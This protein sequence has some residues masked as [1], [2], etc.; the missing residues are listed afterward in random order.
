MGFLRSLRNI[1]NWFTDKAGLSGPKGP[2]KR[3]HEEC[4]TISNKR[5]R[6]DDSLVEIVEIS[7]EFLSETEEVEI[8]EPG[9]ST[10]PLRASPPVMLIE[11][12]QHPRRTMSPVRTIDLTESNDE[13]VKVKIIRSY[14]LSNP[15]LISNRSTE[16]VR[17]A[18]TKAIREERSSIKGS[19]PLSLS[20]EGGFSALKINDTSTNASMDKS[21]AM[22]LKHYVTPKP[23]TNILSVSSSRSPMSNHKENILNQSKSSQT[24]GKENLD[25]PELSIYSNR[26]IKKEL[27]YERILRKFKEKQADAILTS[28]TRIQLKSPDDI[29]QEKLEI[30]KKELDTNEPQKKNEVFP[31]YSEEVVES[32]KLQLSGSLNEYIVQGKTI[33]KMDLKTVY[34][35]SAWLNDEVINHYLSMIVARDPTNIH[36]FDTFF[37][38]KLSSQ[39][40]Q[41][42]RRWSRKKDIFACKKMFSPIHLGNHWCL[43]C[44]NF[45]EK[46]V[47]YYDSLG[48]PNPKCLNLIFDYLKQEYENKKNEQFNSSGW[49]IMEAEDCPSQKNGYDCGVFTCINAEYLSRDAKLDFVQDDMPKLRHRICYEILNNR[50][51]Y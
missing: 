39:G 18:S 25:V 28:A 41:S 15:Q 5:V 35:S 32:I 33:K 24:S 44:V 31:G 29:F 9:P 13:D 16:L 47:K 6:M 11:G 20:M 26:I 4:E 49:Q 3:K 46:T 51:C 50:L 17:S 34:G 40:Y 22:I 30:M 38:S 1:K 36:T 43:I 23:E 10:V 2:T 45:I 21:F 14:S 8:T 48:H 19:K 7:D 27:F 37:Y 42:V 12:R